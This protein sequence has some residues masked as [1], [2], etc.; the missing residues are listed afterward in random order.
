MKKT[1]RLTEEE[2]KRVMHESVKRALENRVVINEHVD[3]ER[4]IV[5]AQ[6]TLCKFPLSKVGLR[7]EGTK[8]YSQF[9]RM[10]DAIV[11]LNN[12]LIK[13]IRKER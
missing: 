8:F 6:K 3:C 7:L 2:L 13:H 10:R 11:E 1:V 4:E 5:L 9:Q 12:S